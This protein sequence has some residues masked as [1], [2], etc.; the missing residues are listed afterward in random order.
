[1]IRR[2]RSSGIMGGRDDDV[3]DI[4]GGGSV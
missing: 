1:L 3:W 4:R 2:R